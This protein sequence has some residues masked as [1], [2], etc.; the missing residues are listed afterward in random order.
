[1]YGSEKIIDRGDQPF[2]TGTFPGVFASGSFWKT[3]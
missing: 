1:M 3:N 2:L